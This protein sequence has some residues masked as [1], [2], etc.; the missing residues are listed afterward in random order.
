MRL[1]L[2]EGILRNKELPGGKWAGVR[3]ASQEKD[4]TMKVLKQDE[5]LESTREAAVHRS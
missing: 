3:G 2:I 1:G 5:A 4:Q